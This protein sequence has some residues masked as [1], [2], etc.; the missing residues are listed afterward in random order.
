MRRQGRNM[1]L[2]VCLRAADEGQQHPDAEAAIQD[3]THVRNAG[4]SS[5]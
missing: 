5:Q 2:P 4:V 3:Q 1:L